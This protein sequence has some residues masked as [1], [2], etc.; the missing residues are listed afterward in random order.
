LAHSNTPIR[1]AEDLKG[2]KYRTSGAWADVMKDYFGAVP[3]VVPPGDTYTLLQR[4]GVDAVEWATPS[5]N[6]PEGFHQAAKYIVVPGVHQATLRG[7]VVMQQESCNKVP[8][9][10]EHLIE[11]A[12]ELNTYQSLD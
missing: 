12:V 2:L 8:V 4:K 1:T 6:T 5:S 11:A 9:D 7:V 3:T 10:L